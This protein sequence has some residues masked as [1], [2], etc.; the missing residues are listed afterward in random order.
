[1][2][3]PLHPS[4]TRGL[5]EFFYSHTQETVNMRYG[6]VKDRLT[7]ESA[8][9]LTS[10]DQTVDAA[11]ALFEEHD[12]RQ[13]ICAVGR[14]YC[15]S[16]GESAEVAFIVG[17]KTRRLGMSRFMLTE[18]ALV[19]RQRGIVTFWASVLKRNKAMAALFE[20][21]GA[22]R[23]SELGE[24]NEEFFLDVAQCIDNLG[25]PS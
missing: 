17:E 4:D 19:A 9:K 14:F 23:E 3:R 8:Y 12:H 5:Q 22:Q 7:D 20:K 6:H 11:F 21:L 10:V 2:F 1:M 16:S 24:D 15:D 25:T 13:E 18:L